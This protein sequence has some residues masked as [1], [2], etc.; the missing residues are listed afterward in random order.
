MGT[1]VLIM[2]PTGHAD[3]SVRSATTAHFLAEC[4][5]ERLNVRR[6][7]VDRRGDANGAGAHCRIDFGIEQPPHDDLGRT[8]G[9]AKRQD[10]RPLLIAPRAQYLAIAL[11]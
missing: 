6:V 4:V 11:P 5:Q 1:S 8:T 2:C 3:S 10:P 9:V 7:I